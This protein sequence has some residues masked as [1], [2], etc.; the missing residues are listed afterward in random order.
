MGYP[1][2]RIFKNHQKQ[3]KNV[4]KRSKMPFFEHF[5]PFLTI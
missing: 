1:W 2:Q 3:P 4:K 5:S